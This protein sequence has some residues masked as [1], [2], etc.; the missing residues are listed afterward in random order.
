MQD[1]ETAA[2]SS[3]TVELV[4]GAPLKKREVKASVT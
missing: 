2:K 3:S 1:A 4:M